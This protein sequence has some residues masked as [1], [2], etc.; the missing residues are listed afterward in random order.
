MLDRL[1]THP[2]SSS[3]SSPPVDVYRTSLAVLRIQEVN[4][5]EFLCFSSA[6]PLWS[7]LWELE[8]VI[9]RNDTAVWCESGEEEGREE[10]RGTKCIGTRK[11]ASS[12]S[13]RYWTTT[14]TC[15][16]GGL[17]GRTDF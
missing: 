9:H 5:S 3:E 15:A 2:A 12:S 4:D 1:L 14:W 13:L 6:S 8:E 10:R 7:R 16:F 17:K 11:I